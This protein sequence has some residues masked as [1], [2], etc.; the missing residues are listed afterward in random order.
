MQM[1]YVQDIYK[2]NMQKE[3]NFEKEKKQIF[4]M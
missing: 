1:R 3:I 4:S 2:R